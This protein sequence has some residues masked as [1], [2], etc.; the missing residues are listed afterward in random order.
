VDPVDELVAVYD[1]D[2]AVVGSATRSRMRAEGLWHATSAVLVRSEDGGRV[3]VHRRTETKD[4]FPGAHDCW[5]GGV[6]AAGETPA[7]GARR[8]LAEEL[9]IRAVPLRPLFS[10]RYD[11][12]P[13]RC[14]GFAFEA[15]WDGP[16]THQPEEVAAGGWMTLDGLRARLADPAWPFTPDSRMLIELWFERHQ[17]GFANP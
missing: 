3:Y 15:R 1:A 12:P 17:S 7:E 8:E 9:G 11:V 14:H 10:A 16:I 2:G 4:V 5:A 13:V 6:V